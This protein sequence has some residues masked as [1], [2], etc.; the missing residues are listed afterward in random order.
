MPFCCKG[1]SCTPAG[2]I[3]VSSAGSVA[4]TV[5][6]GGVATPSFCGV[7]SNAGKARFKGIEAEVS[8]RLARDFAG[9]GSGITL[10]GTAGYIDAEY[11]EYIAIIGGVETNLAPF[12]G[13][14]NTPKFT[15]SA[16]LGTNLPVAGGDLSANLNLAYQDLSDFGGLD[17]ERRQ[18][19]ADL[20]LHYNGW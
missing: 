10:G 6:V 7:V 12:R 17:L 19:I 16:T 20:T 5:N 15:A 18:V 9:P 4:C 1:C 13:I 2:S 3:W 8:A 11:Q 14:Q